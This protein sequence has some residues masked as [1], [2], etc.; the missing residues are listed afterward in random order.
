MVLSED[1]YEFASLGSRAS[2]PTTNIRS[3][4]IPLSPALQQIQ[5]AFL[6][7]EPSTIK[8]SNTKKTTFANDPDDMSDEEDP[9]VIALNPSIERPSM[10]LLEKIRKNARRPQT[11]QAN[12]SK[13]V[14]SV[15]FAKVVF[16]V[17]ESLIVDGSFARKT[18]WIC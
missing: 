3:N 14:A 12:A 9:D 2:R 11:Q 18:G 13:S 15:S 17:F 10:E 5:P 16:F 4:L 7:N 1:Y 8:D 6:A